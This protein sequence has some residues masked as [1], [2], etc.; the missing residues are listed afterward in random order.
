ML[1]SFEILPFVRDEYHIMVRAL[2]VMTI[3]CNKLSRRK[4]P[5]SKGGLEPREANN[6]TGYHCNAT[7]HNLH[8]LS[9]QCKE[10]ADRVEGISEAEP[11][12]WTQDALVR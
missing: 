1:R 2:P 6:G 4:G 3:S 10:R 11:G 9:C 8:R 7:C 5:L 12:F